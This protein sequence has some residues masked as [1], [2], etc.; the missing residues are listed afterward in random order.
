M[1]RKGDN[2]PP[3]GVAPLDP[4]FLVLGLSVEPKEEREKKGKERTEPIGRPGSPL[5]YAS[6]LLGIEREAARRR[7]G[8]GRK[9]TKRKVGAS[10]ITYGR[11]SW[12]LQLVAASRRDCANFATL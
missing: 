5:V 7:G 10:D 6:L 12:K 11:K 8:K 2:V 9:Q 1:E 4:Y 3:P